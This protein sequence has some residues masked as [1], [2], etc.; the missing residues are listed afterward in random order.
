MQAKGEGLSYRTVLTGGTGEITEKK[1]RFIADILPVHTTE[2][3]EAFLQTVKKKYR[4][5]SHHC[6]AFI[7]GRNAQLERAND[8]G[9]PSGTAGRPLL[10][11]LQKEELRDVCIV[12]TRYFGGT[13][14]GT[15]GLARAYTQAAKA[16][17]SDCRIVTMRRG[18]RLE[19]STS[20]SDAGRVQY[21]LEKR[22][23]EPEE[24]RYEEQVTF[25]VLL[26]SEE[27]EELKTRLSD[28]TCAAAMV[29]ELGSSYYVDKR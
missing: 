28:T 5:A 11:V 19:I 13:L 20:Y 15:G 18:E 29:K 7:I 10:E 8:D 26:P 25:R 23:L 21:L 4:D 2:E 17:L 27:K 22:R 3:A 6:S 9:E 12:V 16:G 14:L 1:S 24:I